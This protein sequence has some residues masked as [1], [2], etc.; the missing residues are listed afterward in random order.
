VL[1]LPLLVLI[2]FSTASYICQVLKRKYKTGRAYGDC[3]LAN[4]Y[5]TYHLSKKSENGKQIPIV[6]AAHPGVISGNFYGPSEF[7][8]MH[9]SPIK[10]ESSKLSHNKEA[11]QKLWDISEQLTTIKY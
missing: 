10:I 8:E 6:V 1:T 9:S 7:R 2:L 11:A 5:F 4:L 3:K